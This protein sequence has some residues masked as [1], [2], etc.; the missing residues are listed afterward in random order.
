MRVYVQ[1]RGTT[2]DYAF[3][4]A[5]PASRWWLAFRDATSFEQPTLIVSGDRD[6]WRCYLSGIPS[7]RTDRVG[8]TIRYTFV[9]EGRCGESAGDALRLVAMW[10]GDATD[11]GPGLRVQAALDGV[12][13]EATVERL[14]AVRGSDSASAIE[15]ERLA[16]RSMANLPTST[17]LPISTEVGSWAGSTTS[18]HAQRELLARIAELIG[19]EREGAAAL[20]NLL[21]TADEVARLAGQVGPL[22]ALIEDPA[23]ALGDRLVSVEKKKLGG[24]QPAPEQPPSDGPMG[25]DWRAD[26]RNLAGDLVAQPESLETAAPH[27]PSA[28]PTGLPTAPAAPRRAPDVPPSH[29]GPVPLC[30]FRLTIDGS[31]SGSHSSESPKTLR[32]YFSGKW[33]LSLKSKSVLSA[34]IEGFVQVEGVADKAPMKGTLTVRRPWGGF[35]FAG[36]FTD[37]RGERCSINAKTRSVVRAAA[38]AIS[39][40]G[41]L[42][43]GEIP[44]GEVDLR[45]DRSTL[46]GAL[47]S[48]D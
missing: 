24:R 47:P 26:R 48:L 30:G 41:I 39:V 3:L 28:R 35:D 19:G 29:T 36:E 32:L 8:T 31:W 17:Q 44:F 27:P 6:E 46:K 5:A 21:G 14:L 2:A 12:F 42:R 1:T 25:G 15:V 10:L 34:E 20:L 40:G 7:R 18:A 23:G 45:V 13:D 37:S 33:Q 9:L 43:R 22:V 4:G 38:G 16:A 11:R